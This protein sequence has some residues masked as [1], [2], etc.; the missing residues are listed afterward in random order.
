VRT[1]LKVRFPVE[2]SNKA[3]KD[4]TLE[5]TFGK[6]LEQLKPEAAYFFPDGGQRSALFVFDLKEPS[7]IVLA[8]EP[9]FS[10]MEAEVSLV[11]VMNGDDLK[12]GLAKLKKA[13]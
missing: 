13:G 6:M 11:P 9:F 12:A 8:A 3:V 5:K 10:A 1:M 7:D 2:A 4:G